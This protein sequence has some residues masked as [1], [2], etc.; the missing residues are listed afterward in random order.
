VQLSWSFVYP[1][2]YLFGENCI[3]DVKFGSIGNRALLVF[4]RSSAKKNGSYEDLIA[5]LTNDN[6]EWIEYWGVEED[7]SWS[8]VESIAAKIR[9]FG[10][11]FVVAVGGG[12]PIDAAKA[13][14][15]VAKT[16]AS[17][18]ELFSNPK[19]EALPLVAISTTSGTGSEVTPFSVI[20]KDDGLK[21]GF[22][23]VNIYPKVAVVDYRYTLTCP[24]SV[25]ITTALDAF[26]HCFEG[27]CS[28]RTN[29][30]ARMMALHGMK[31]IIENLDNVLENP[32]YEEGRRKLAFAASLGGFVISMTGTLFS[33]AASYPLT[34]YYGIRHGEAVALVA[35][36]MIVY[37]EEWILR[38][39]EKEL[40]IENFS[41]WFVNWL[42]E[43][44][45]FDHLKDYSKS[46]EDEYLEWAEW[47]LSGTRKRYFDV[48]PAKIGR[49]EILKIY[50]ELKVV[51]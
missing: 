22:F 49:E 5:K 13:A 3:S 30:M 25:T 15:V 45:V 38:M 35:S 19:L 17:W 43:L 33:H 31:L 14:C 48:T 18:D 47:L 8:T 32:V 50:E 9:E 11:E 16:G 42:E 34:V 28:L 4:G 40:G 51:E 41:K 12:S 27:Y 23:N 24:K 21:E 36:K 44:G 7:P 29:E 2:R 39:L 10:A 6:V 1:G 20:K 46:T 37:M 26:M